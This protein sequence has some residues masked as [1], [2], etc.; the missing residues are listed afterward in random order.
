LRK[1]TETKEDALRDTPSA[2]VSRRRTVEST[3]TSSA[4]HR[5]E[6]LALAN[7]AACEAWIATIK[8]E[9]LYD[10]DTADMSPEKVESMI[11]RFIDFCNNDRF[12]QALDYL[13]P[14]EPHDG[15]HTGSSRRE[16]AGCRKRKSDG[17]WRPA[18]GGQILSVKALT[19]ERDAM[20]RGERC[21]G[22]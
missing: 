12:H 10:A 15:R 3:S 14:A 7:T 9:Q 19:M 5:A 16:G 6:L 17:G 8:Y 1:R 21:F 2:A 18:E 4:G 11:D 22:L 13:T 20:D